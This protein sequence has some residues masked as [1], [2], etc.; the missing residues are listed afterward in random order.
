[1]L[2]AANLACISEAY[3]VTDSP[4]VLDGATVIVVEPP[5]VVGPEMVRLVVGATVAGAVNPVFGS[6]YDP[7]S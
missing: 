4:A 6:V 7:K 5:V 3:C 2:F 1:M